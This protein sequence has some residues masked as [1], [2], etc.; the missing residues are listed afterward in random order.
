MF[1]P[2]GQTFVTVL[3]SHC[4]SAIWQGLHHFCITLCFNHLVRASS[5]SW[6]HVVFQPFGKGLIT[7]AVSCCVQPFDKGLVT[8]LVSRCVS[9]IWQ[10]PHHCCSVTLCFSHLAKPS[11]LSWCHIVFQPFGKGFITFVSH[12]VLIIW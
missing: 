11:S 5:L 9:A 10:G 8:V 1:Q 12:C 3:V 6:Y 7:A 4:I 2:F